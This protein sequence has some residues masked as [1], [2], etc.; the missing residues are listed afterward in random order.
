MKSV[1]ERN[2]ARNNVNIMTALMK[3]VTA[4]FDTSNEFMA[5]QLFSAI[6]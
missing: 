4:A 2:F 6:L 5:M 1:R 3:K